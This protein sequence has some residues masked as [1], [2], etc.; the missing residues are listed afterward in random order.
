[1]KRIGCGIVLILMSAALLSAENFTLYAGNANKTQF[2][3]FAMIGEIGDFLQFHFDAMKYLKKDQSLFSDIPARDRSDLLGVS[4]LFVLKLPIHLL[5]YLDRLDYIQPYLSTGAGLAVE[6]LTA[7]YNDAPNAADGG[8]GLFRKIRTF[9]SFG[10]GVIVMISAEFG[11]KIDF[12]KID[13]TAHSGMG[14]P[15]RKFDRI[16]VGVCFGPYKTP[17]KRIKK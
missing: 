7:D 12:R 14:L 11:I 1:M 2:F 9:F 3:G 15:A 5:P 4:G 16:S 17:I 13:M 8:T 10:Y 6:S